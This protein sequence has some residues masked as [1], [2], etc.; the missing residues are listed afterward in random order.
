MAQGVVAWPEA[1]A[2]PAR[3]GAQPT[4][5]IPQRRP[6]HHPNFCIFLR[7]FYWHLCL[8]IPRDPS[9]SCPLAHGAGG[10]PQ[11][12]PW[13]PGRSPLGSLHKHLVSAAVPRHCLTPFLGRTWHL[14]QG[15]CHHRHWQ[16][17]LGNDSLQNKKNQ[18]QKKN[19]NAKERKRKCFIYVFIYLFGTGFFKPIHLGSVISC[20][21]LQPRGILVKCIC[22]IYFLKNAFFEQKS[23]QNQ[24]RLK[25]KKSTR[26]KRT[27]QLLSSLALSFPF[28]C[29][30]AP[31]PPFFLVVLPLLY[32]VPDWNIKQWSCPAVRWEHGYPDKQS[33]LLRWL[34]S[35]LGQG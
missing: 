1:A 5:R 22:L 3:A 27:E 10:D 33:S 32:S 24:L 7:G 30:M 19:T 21:W 4:L 2:G 34:P 25:K 13:R 8:C 31:L 11:R 15:C 23:N 20:Q 6:P 9:C 12:G 35:F 18:Q 17:P 29:C 16:R 26:T 14:S 28:L